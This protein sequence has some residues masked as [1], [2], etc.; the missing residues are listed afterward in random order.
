[1]SDGRPSAVVNRWKRPRTR[2]ATPPPFVPTQ[3]FPSRSSQSARIPLFP[4]PSSWVKTANRVPSKRASPSYVPSQT[5][6]SRVSRT[7][8]TVAL[9]RP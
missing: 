6:P 2:R 5:Y 8:V 3:R 1:M 9:G 4:S 7:A